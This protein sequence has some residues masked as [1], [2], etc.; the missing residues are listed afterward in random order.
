MASPN[1]MIDPDDTLMLLIDHQ[2][3]LF[4]TVRDILVPDLRNYATAL[5][6]TATLLK[7]PVLTTASVSDGSNG[8]LIQ[9]F[10]STRPMPNTSH[11]PVKSMRWI[12]LPMW[13][14]LKNQVASRW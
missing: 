2:S 1:G 3:G 11:E 5:A 13:R 4:N 9:K 10:I 8:P 6:K 7:I 12:I 14:R